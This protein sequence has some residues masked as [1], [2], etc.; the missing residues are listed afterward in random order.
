MASFPRHFQTF[1]D[2]LSP[3]VGF[4]PGSVSS[5]RHYLVVLPSSRLVVLSLFGGRSPAYLRKDCRGSRTKQLVE[6]Y[7]ASRIPF[8]LSHRNSARLSFALIG[9]IVIAT[10]IALALALA[11]P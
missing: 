6:T 4:A 7:L 5:N 1:E 3:E 8:R 9:S 2:I 10:A 11:H